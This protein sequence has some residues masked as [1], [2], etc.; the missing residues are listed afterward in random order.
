[1][2]IFHRIGKGKGGFLRKANQGRIPCPCVRSA[3]QDVGG[4]PEIEGIAYLIYRLGE[5]GTNFAGGKI[6]PVFVGTLI[7]K[8]A[9]NVD[10]L[11]FPQIPHRITWR[12]TTVNKNARRGNTGFHLFY[13]TFILYIMAIITVTYI[14]SNIIIKKTAP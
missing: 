4:P 8:N 13:F 11:V 6:L 10:M 9:Q 12:V 5:W 14:D 7:V 2:P 1:M 3:F